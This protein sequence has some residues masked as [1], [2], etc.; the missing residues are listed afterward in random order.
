M[1][2]DGVMFALRKVAVGARKQQKRDQMMA[3]GIAQAA[4][5]FGKPN[6]RLYRFNRHIHFAN[7]VAERIN[8]QSQHLY[9]PRYTTP[10]KLCKF[11]DR[12]MFGNARFSG[13]ARHHRWGGK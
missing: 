13:N 8:K 3:N 1:G 5:F 12:M 11:D 7:E 6:L 4:Q 9:W 10:A 2:D